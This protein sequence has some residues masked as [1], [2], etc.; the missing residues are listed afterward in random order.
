MGE[1]PDRKA[2][3]RLYYKAY[4]AEHRETLL[5]KLRE[6]ARRHYAINKE[7]IRATKLANYHVMK[8]VPGKKVR[9]T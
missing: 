2:A 1:T 9:G 3:M 5:P 7:R 8:N 4:Y 6:N